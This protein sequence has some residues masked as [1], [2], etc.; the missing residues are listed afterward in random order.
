MGKSFGIMD[1]KFFLSIDVIESWHI[2][3]SQICF[4]ASVMVELP[5]EAWK[6]TSQSSR[7]RQKF[8]SLK[9]LSGL[10][11]KAANDHS[12]TMK[13]ASIAEIYFA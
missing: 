4:L 11:F 13:S 3:N 1:L 10:Y 8:I 6:A 9:F 2:R 12:N 7:N 5:F